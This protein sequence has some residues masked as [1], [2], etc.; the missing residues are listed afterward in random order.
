MHYEDCQIKVNQLE[1]WRDIIGV[2]EKH[3]LPSLVG[4][5]RAYL[6]R[7]FLLED[8]IQVSPKNPNI[9]VRK[10]VGVGVQR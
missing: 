3:L 7:V 8:G 10:K 9:K 4:G 2:R 6:E 5:K 1:R